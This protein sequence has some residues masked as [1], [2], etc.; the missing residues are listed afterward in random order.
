MKSLIYILIGLFVLCF[1]ANTSYGQ[2]WK[3]NNKGA[4]ST[5]GRKGDSFSGKSKKGPNIY[6]SKPP[7]TKSR[8]KLYGH[9]IS[10]KKLRKK[11]KSEFSATKSRYKSI[12][13]KPKGKGDK[14]AKSSSGGRKSGKGRKKEK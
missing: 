6:S 11:N 2:F 12:N 4:T 13:S 14:G 5:N 1:T 3:K 8:S 7:R 10:K 9:S